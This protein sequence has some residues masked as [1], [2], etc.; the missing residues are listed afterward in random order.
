MIGLAQFR[1]L[2]TREQA[3]I[4]VA[5]LLDGREAANYLRN[6]PK[7]GA[8]MYQIATE[9]ASITPQLRMPLLGSLLRSSLNA[10]K[11]RGA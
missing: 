2:E 11:G 5:V 3:L 9:L 1:S 8:E 7:R 10:V 6:D 4:A